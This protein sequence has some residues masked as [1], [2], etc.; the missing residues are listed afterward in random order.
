MPRTASEDTGVA[1]LDDAL[2]DMGNIGLQLRILSD[3]RLA[4]DLPKGFL[5][6]RRFR[7][8]RHELACGPANINLIATRKRN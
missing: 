8:H 2:A 3:G 7:L 5:P 1:R 6:E 4:R